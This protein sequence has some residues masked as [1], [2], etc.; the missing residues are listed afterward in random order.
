M[1]TSMNK[2]LKGIFYTGIFILLLFEVIN[3]YFI[4]PMPGSQEFNS[5]DTA[6]FL[7][8]H[9][10]YFRIACGIM[11]FSGIKSSFNNKIRLLPVLS[12]V[13]VIVVIYLFNFR[14]N[15]DS[16]F[17]Q[18]EKLTFQPKSGNI[19]SDS[20]LVIC[21]ENNG[22]AKGYPI[23]FLSYHHQ[24]QDTIG[25]LPLIITYCNVCRTGRAFK[26]E[27]KGVHEKFRLVGMDHYNAMFEDE[28]TGS[29]WRQSTGEA[30]AGPLKGEALEEAES[31]QL[32]VRK[33][34]ELYPGA[35]VMQ[36][37]E[38]SRMKY[39]SLGKF[40]QGKSTGRLTRSD[41]RSWETKSWVVG[42][43]AGSESKAYDWNELIK[44][45]I[46]NDKIGEKPI[47]LVLSV[48]GQS[49]M[50]FERPADSIIFNIRN[51]TIVASGSLYDLSGKSLTQ[52]APR[53]K[54]LLCYQEFWHSWQAFHP[55][56]RQ[57]K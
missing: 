12:L 38:L 8:I 5:I 42:V 36:A 55:G 29:W 9:R 52:A 39:D 27:V 19:V 40:E 1:Y 35:L 48:D 44:Q 41:T 7:Y 17:R 22:I 6:Y 18:P 25:G 21:V 57:N 13:T 46:I 30:V 56:K 26:P 33:L 24:V 14:M 32:T 3:V 28:T 20:S 10:W 47:A 53:L 31:M 34:F 54:R 43:K 2:L 51:D 16:M 23:R 15:A 4:M 50:A 49:F 11:I 37:D 45:H